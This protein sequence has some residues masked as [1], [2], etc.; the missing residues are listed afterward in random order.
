MNKEL[1]TSPH[2]SSLDLHQKTSRVQTMCKPFLAIFWAISTY[3]PRQS[4]S[5]EYVDIPMSYDDAEAYCQSEFDSHLATIRNIRDIAYAILATPYSHHLDTQ[6]WMGLYSDEPN[7]WWTFKSDSCPIPDTG[8]CVD[9]WGTINRGR[10]LPLC[11]D[12][13]S[14]YSCGYF[15]PNNQLV[16]N[17]LDCNESRPFLCESMTTSSND[18][19]GTEGTCPC[20][21]TTNDISSCNSG[22]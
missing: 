12:N 6:T 8:A 19:L 15:M 5:L 21:I 10:N 2:L 13:T 14:G 7:G 1:P 11:I 17:D 22:Y 18:V 9:N 16:Y 3:I 20:N 4:Q